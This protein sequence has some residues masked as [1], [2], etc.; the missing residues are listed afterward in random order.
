MMA[1]VDGGKCSG[2]VLGGVL[3]V[4]ELEFC[5]ECE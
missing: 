1:Y 4:G 3:V 2:S 5:G